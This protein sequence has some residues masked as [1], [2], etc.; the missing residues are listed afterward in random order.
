MPLSF[1]LACCWA[2]WHC[3]KMKHF[4]IFFVT[5]MALQVFAIFLRVNNLHNFGSDLIL[6]VGIYFFL[7]IPF[8]F[9]IVGL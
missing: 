4:P 8:L 2:T 9:T 5:H 7:P 1:E 6:W 3:L